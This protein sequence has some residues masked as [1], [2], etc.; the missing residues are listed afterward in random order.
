MYINMDLKNI[1][2]WGRS[3]DEYTQIF[4]LTKADL[5]KYILG[6]GDA[7]ASFN[8]ELSA[9][10]GNV[11]SIDPTYCFNAE[12]LQYRI[13]EVYD[14]VMPQMPLNKDKYVWNS[15]P[16]VKALG[17]IRMSSMDRF[18]VDYDSGKEEGRYIEA[19]LPELSFKDK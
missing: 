5:K 2:A 6:C 19:S 12:Q 3:F 4:S 10:G 1:V 14:E 17:S 18:I 15:V 16:S 13:T 7:P 9:Q 8:A 11:L